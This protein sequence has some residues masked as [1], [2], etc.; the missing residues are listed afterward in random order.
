MA[1]SSDVLEATAEEAVGHPA[2]IVHDVEA[3]QVAVGRSARLVVV[4]VEAQHT[5]VPDVPLV[6]VDVVEEERRD[7]LGGHVAGELGRAD[8]GGVVDRVSRREQQ[9]AK[10]VSVDDGKQRR[11]IRVHAEV[12]VAVGNLHPPHL[13]HVRIEQRVPAAAAVTVLVRALVAPADAT[14]E[15]VALNRVGILCAASG[16]GPAVEDGGLQDRLEDGP[17]VE[18]ELVAI[19]D[20]NGAVLVQEVDD[21]GDDG[22][23][24]G[25]GPAAL[26]RPPHDGVGP[27]ALRVTEIVKPRRG[28]LSGP[29]LQRV[30]AGHA[31][32]A[33]AVANAAIALVAGHGSLASGSR[34]WLD[35]FQQCRRQFLRVRT[36]SQ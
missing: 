34:M 1:E 6:Q 19:T 18:G 16:V 29:V 21:D 27:D 2:R 33:R 26:R 17:R 35:A 14:Q 5:A 31:T 10:D 25:G 28:E 13:L 12:P 15:L 11:T 4:A 20:G 30:D 3:R 32:G 7:V 36:R 8:D 24:D 22:R 9:I 23:M